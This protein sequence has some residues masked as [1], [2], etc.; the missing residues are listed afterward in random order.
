MQTA[1]TLFKKNPLI[2]KTILFVLYLYYL[3]LY[4]GLTSFYIIPVFLKLYFNIP[5]Q[6]IIRIIPLLYIADFTAPWIT[7][8]EYGHYS[9]ITFLKNFYT[10]KELFILHV[11]AILIFSLITY[12]ILFNL[13]KNFKNNLF[14]LAICLMLI[15]VSHYVLLNLNL[16]PE[17]ITHSSAVIFLVTFLFSKKIWILY[18]A[19]ITSNYLNT[20]NLKEY[21]INLF[22]YSPFYRENFR[23][24]SYIEQSENENI[25]LYVQS[26]LSV[27]FAIAYFFFM[28][29]LSPEFFITELAVCPGQ[30]SYQ[31]Y[32]QNI[33]DNYF[34]CFTISSFLK[35][36]IKHLFIDT[37]L[38]VIPGHLVGLHFRLPFGN[39]LKAKSFPELLSQTMYYYTLVINRIF[40][41]EISKY[42]RLKSRKVSTALITFVSVFVGGLFF[43]LNRDLNYIVVF[44][45]NYY[46]SLLEGPLL[47]FFLLSIFMTLKFK[48]FKLNFLNVLIWLFMLLIVRSLNTYY[49]LEPLTFKIQ[50]LMKALFWWNSLE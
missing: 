37:L 24:E 18:L 13:L 10:N 32:L 8:I 30:V 5:T 45:K 1:I 23:L 31:Y 11:S 3:S 17:K 15:V 25:K 39:F 41:W 16:S 48:L 29:F 36:I 46:G 12:F 28:K 26:F 44:N 22:N 27:L 47:Y 20:V 33:T 7:P 40:I 4:F 38:L 6:K 49:F 42:L 50:Y 35:G 2:S 9:L 34:T 43:H 19:K 14:F 21:L